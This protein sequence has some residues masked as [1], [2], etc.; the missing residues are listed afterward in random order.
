MEAAAGVESFCRALHLPARARSPPL[1]DH[2]GRRLR[3]FADLV[4]LLHQPLYARAQRVA[5]AAL[6]HFADADVAMAMV[7]RE[8]LCREA[9]RVMRC[10]RLRRYERNCGVRFDV[11]R[12]FHVAGARQK[13]KDCSSLLK[14]TSA[15]THKHFAISL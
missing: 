12:F 5:A 9:A 11:L 6:H 7:W 13:N 8:L 10:C 2:D 1:T 14:H 4:V 15:S 3:D